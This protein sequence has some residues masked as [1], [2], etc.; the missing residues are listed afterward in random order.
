MRKYF[1]TDG[2]RARVGTH[3]MMPEVVLKFGWAVGKSLPDSEHKKVLIGKDTRVSG[4]MFESAL[5]AGLLAAGVDIL[6]L[7]PLPTP[8]VACLTR[9][10]HANAGLV[11]SASH[12]FYHDNGIKLFSKHGKKLS[13]A[14]EQSI[15][16]WMERPLETS[17]FLGKARRVNDAVGRYIE[18]CKRS[19]EETVDFQGMT[20][21]IDCANGAG[22][23]VAPTVF[24]ELGANVH[25]IGVSPDGFNINSDCGVLNPHAL[26]SRVLEKKADFGIAIDGDGDRLL[27]V[28]EKGE[29]LDGDQL[30][31]IIVA[32]RNERGQTVEGV[33][34]TQMSNMGFEHALLE[35]GIDFC[36]TQVGDRH[37][38]HALEEKKWLIGGEPSGHIICLDKLPTGDATLAALQVV[39]ALAQSGKPLSKLKQSMSM[40]PQMLINIPFQE[41]ECDANEIEAITVKAKKELGE[42]ARV[43]VRVSGTEPVIRVMVEAKSQSDCK[44]YAERVAREIRALVS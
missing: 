35:R 10:L 27:M 6:L 15:E 16:A 19:L 41:Q 2:I 9:T 21:V 13:D 4:Y 24:E 40:Y 3:P 32:A 14:E 20:C 5:Q 23:Q 29:T 12:N 34:G 26:Q 44:Q 22:Y 18:F 38:T 31:M 33:V 39:N 7:G 37:I 36:R 25:T 17:E 28:D 8:G 42:Q 43:V 1:G 30:L 11:I